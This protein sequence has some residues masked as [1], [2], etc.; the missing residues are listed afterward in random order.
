MLPAEEM[1]T[2][3]QHIRLMRG[4]QKFRQWNPEGLNVDL[5]LHIVSAGYGVVAGARRIAPYEATFSG[6]KVKALRTWA[7]QLNIATD[8]R[9]ILSQ[10]YDL[11][12]ILLGDAYLNACNF[13]LNVKLGGLTL[14]FCGSRMA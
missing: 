12:L 5:S 6:M 10:P 7:D 11:A 3:Q 8:I 9:A 14:A 2:G 1:Y 4:V 13:D